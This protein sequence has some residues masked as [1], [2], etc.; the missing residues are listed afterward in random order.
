[1]LLPAVTT[2]LTTNLQG[3][4]DQ[5]IKGESIEHLND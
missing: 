4:R 1:L 5:R 3:R 2:V